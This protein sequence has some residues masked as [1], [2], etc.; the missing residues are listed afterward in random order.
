M[1]PDAPMPPANL[2]PGYIA[3]SAIEALAFGFAVAFAIFGWPAIRRLSLGASWLNK[4]LFVTLCWFMGNWW[5]H[6]NLHMHNGMN[7]HGL[8]FIEIAFHITMLICGVTL[9]LSF[10]RLAPT[11]RPEMPP[12][13]VLWPRMS[14]TA[15]YRESRR[16]DRLCK[17]L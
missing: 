4:W 6:D 14:I 10:L 16:S 15:R 17:G 12:D 1:S 2:L 5:M 3:L 7:M 13:H 8:L 11:R 9:A